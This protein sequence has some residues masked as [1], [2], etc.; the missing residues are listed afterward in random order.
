M[1]NRIGVDIIDISRLEDKFDNLS[2]LLSDRELKELSTSSNK[3][4]RLASSLA[5]KEAFIKAYGQSLELKNKIKLTSIELLHDESTNKPRVYYQNVECGDISI[6][7]DKFAI[8]FLI[9]FKDF[10]I[11]N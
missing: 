3:V 5:T 8:A 9:L 6:S 7:H 1:E 11:K 4:E 2:K 10:K